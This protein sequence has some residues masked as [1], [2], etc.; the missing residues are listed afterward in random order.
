MKYIFEPI[1]E[2]MIANGKNEAA[3]EN[4][5]NNVMTKYGTVE[6]FVVQEVVVKEDEVV[7]NVVE[8][9]TLDQNE[10]IISLSAENEQLSI[11][12]DN[13]LDENEK[14]KEE[15]ESLRLA[16]KELEYYK[17]YKWLIDAFCGLKVALKDLKQDE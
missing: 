16:K 8:E 14:L 2:T 7:L 12:N 13:L 15:V 3:L 11:E 6:E 1:N 10:E 4:F 17:Q 9:S 5:K